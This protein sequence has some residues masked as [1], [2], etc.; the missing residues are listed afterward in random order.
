MNKGY[1]VPV[2]RALHGTFARET[3]MRNAFGR[4]MPLKGNGIGWKE[5]PRIAVPFRDKNITEIAA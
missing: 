2:G 4:V 3:V 5:E 1:F